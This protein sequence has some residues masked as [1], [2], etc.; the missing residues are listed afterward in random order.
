MKPLY[1]DIWK[2]VKINGEVK[3]KLTFT[4]PY[5]QVNEFVDYFRPQFIYELKGESGSGKSV[6][7][8]SLLNNNKTHRI[9]LIDPLNSYKPNSKNIIHKTDIFYINELKN[10]L[11]QSVNFI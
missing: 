8:K 2:D 4:S 11:N 9:L 5:E 3:K 1:N 6:F 10:I 7:L